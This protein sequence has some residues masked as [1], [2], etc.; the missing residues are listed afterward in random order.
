MHHFEA[1]EAILLCSNKSPILKEFTYNIDAKGSILFTFAN[2]DLIRDMGYKIYFSVHVPAIR[3]VALKLAR[4][5][6]GADARL[7]GTRAQIIKQDM[8]YSQSPP[9]EIIR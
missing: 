6:W 9:V 7:E 5:K 3:E 4:A 1:Q 8:D 2:G